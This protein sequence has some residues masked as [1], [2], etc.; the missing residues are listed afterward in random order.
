MSGTSLKFGL[1]LYQQRDSTPAPKA[2]MGEGGTGGGILRARNCR[3]AG[4][5]FEDVV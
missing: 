2:K 3:G 5:G 1:S 4:Q